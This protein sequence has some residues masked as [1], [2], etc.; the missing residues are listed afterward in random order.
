MVKNIL[1]VI[2]GIIISIHTVN[3]DPFVYDY[4][5][6]AI[7]IFWNKLYPAGGW[8][9]YCGYRFEHDRKINGTKPVSIEHIYPT[10]EIARQLNCGSRMQC[11]DSGNKLFARMEADMHNM[12]PEWSPLITYRDGLRYGEIQGEQW[13]F[14]D[15][16]IEWQ[17]GVLEPR[18]L[19][20]GNIARA[21]LY[22]HEHYGL[23]LDLEIR[24]LMVL[25]NR[26]DPP[27]NQEIERNDQI[28]AIQGNRNPFIDDPARGDKFK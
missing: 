25:W 27:S 23:K 12:Y 5:Q 9:L 19:A 28:E 11:R 18:P 2:F 3:G 16:D 6:I 26:D 8:T 21:M 1:L 13:R 14:E 15:C 7:D 17:G 22:M 24:R 20:R 4:D 10:A